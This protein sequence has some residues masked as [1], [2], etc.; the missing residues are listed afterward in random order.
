MC[1]GGADKCSSYSERLIAVTWCYVTNELFNS[2]LNPVLDLFCCIDRA[3]KLWP[4]VV[5]DGQDSSPAP[6]EHTERQ[7]TFNIK[8]LVL[9][10][11]CTSIIWLVDSMLCP[12]LKY[13]LTKGKTVPSKIMFSVKE[14]HAPPLSLLVVISDDNKRWHPKHKKIGKHNI[15]TVH[16]PYCN[17]FLT[18]YK[19]IY[20]L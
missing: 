18:Y 3:A 14:L 6:H 1:K 12:V 15:L 7:E 11:A 10:M 2:L 13:T 5:A 8:S 17:N 19:S 16:F 4:W 20:Q 9:Q